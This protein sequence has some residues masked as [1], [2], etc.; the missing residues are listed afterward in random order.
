MTLP[1]LMYLVYYSLNNMKI[2][3]QSIKPKNHFIMAFVDSIT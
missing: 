1:S 2:V 3:I